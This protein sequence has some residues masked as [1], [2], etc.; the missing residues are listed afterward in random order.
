[1]ALQMLT[2][3]DVCASKGFRVCRVP[4]A[5]ALERL[6]LELCT[7]FAADVLAERHWS[8]D[9]ERFGSCA[10]HN[11]ARASVQ[12]SLYRQARETH[13]ERARFILG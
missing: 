3:L 9:P 5:D 6:S 8:W 2:I 4:L 10:E 7:R 12:W 13:A 11:W 1:M